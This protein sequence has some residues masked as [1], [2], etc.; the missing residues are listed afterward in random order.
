MARILDINCSNVL[1]VRPRQRGRKGDSQPAGEGRGRSSLSHSGGLLDY[2][3]KSLV[4]GGYDYEAVERKLGVSA[5]HMRRVVELMGEME[6]EAEEART[7]S[8]KLA[9]REALTESV[10]ARG[11]TPITHAEI[12]RVYEGTV[13]RNLPAREVAREMGITMARLQTVRSL[14]KSRGQWPSEGKAVAS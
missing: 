6:L 11:F 2:W 7:A 9:T 4:A 12:A 3:L 13:V 14:A 8:H 10:K 1:R 5:S